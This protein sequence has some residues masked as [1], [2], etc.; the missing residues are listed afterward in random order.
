MKQLL[1]H[2]TGIDRCSYTTVQGKADF[3]GASQLKCALFIAKTNKNNSEAK[4]VMKKLNQFCSQ[5]L[6]LT[7]LGKTSF[8]LL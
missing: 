7:L 2:I 1:S 4:G 5:L 6:P 3:A 8:F